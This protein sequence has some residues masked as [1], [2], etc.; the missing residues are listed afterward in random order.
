MSSNSRPPEENWA[1]AVEGLLRGEPV[2]IPTETVYGLAARIDDPNAIDRIFKVKERPFF[3]PLIVHLAQTQDVH[4]AVSIFPPLAEK[5]AQAFWPGPLTLVLPKHHDLNPKITSGLET[6]GVR[7]P[8]HSLAQKLIQAVGSPL[9]APSANKFGHTSPTCADHVRSEFGP[10]V[11]VLDGGPCEVGVE[12]TV[13]GFNTDWTEILIY[14]PGAV[15]A[16]MLS[17]FAPV[18]HQESPA[19]PGH[20]A[21]HYMPK[22]PL[23]ILAG[24]PYLH[25]DQYFNLAQQLGVAHPYPSWMDLPED[26]RLAA[27]CLYSELRRAAQQ[28]LANC[29][30]LPYSLEQKSHGLYSAIS[31]RL[32]KAATV[33][34][35]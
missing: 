25:E 16:E 12:S 33:T 3:D 23:V 34:L 5:L 1:R 17:T 19:A 13:V 14:R 9:A 27:R 2:A 20:L 32:K 11:H 15:T 10:Q 30:I 8:R 7:V 35:R 28:K 18:R 4:K 22:I 31:D 21:H 6:V 26:P 29:I 24:S